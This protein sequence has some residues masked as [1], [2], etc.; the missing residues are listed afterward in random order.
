MLNV[1]N[2]FNLDNKS[3]S[4]ST[5]TSILQRKRRNYVLNLAEAFE[6]NTGDIVVVVYWKDYIVYR[7]EGLCI[8]IKKKS[9]KNLDVSLVLR[10]VILGVGVE[11]TVSYFF[12]RVYNLSL[13]DYK[14]KDFFYKRSKLFYVRQRMNKASR[15]K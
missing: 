14:R 10:N 3:L 5:E 12:N 8:A 15:I 2:F 9:L 7:F 13:S 11:V 4:A 1:E 6:F